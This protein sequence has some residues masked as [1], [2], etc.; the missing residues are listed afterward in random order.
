[1]SQRELDEHRRYLAD[2][3]RA[4]A[5]RAAL[6]EVVEPTD[7]VLDLGSGSGLLGYLACEAGAT[8]VIAVDQGDVV[9]LARRI[10]ADNGY[11][12]RISH[13][14]ALSIELEL[15]APVDV[16]VCDQIGGLVHDAGILS[17][18]ADARHRLLAPGGR[19]VPAAFRIFLAPV[20]F[21]AGRHAVEFWSSRPSSTDV[22][23][24]RTMAANTEWKYHVAA[25]DLVALAPGAA[26]SS[27]PSDHDGPISGTLRYE[28]GEAGRLDGF[29]GW[30]EARMSPS[31]TMTN[32]P[33]SPDRFDRWCNFYATEEAVELRPG[34]Q[35]RVQLDIRP[36]LG[37]VSWATEL[38]QGN[39]GARRMRQSTLHG[40]LITASS[41]DDNAPG[42]AIPNSGRVEMVRA[43]VD[44]IDGSRTQA[45]IVKALD[46][47]VGDGFVS[48][49]HLEKFVRDVVALGRG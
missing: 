42:R 43:V 12:D 38:V 47:R 14:Q 6:A 40:S 26:L 13:L 9:G 35:V 23:A 46:D 8:S 20:T 45:D 17:C 34:D 3:R 33:W 37:V 18:F 48:R 1:M 31:V 4:A 11:A 28:V 29:I 44:L 25:D 24:A 5:Y 41:L 27:F 10:A 16:V 7:V 32:D 2:E 30:F 15:D 49:P 21:D 36:R 19:L 39:D 22:G